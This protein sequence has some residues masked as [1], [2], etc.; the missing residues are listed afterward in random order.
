[1]KGSE[2][3]L[4]KANDLV[5]DLNDYPGLSRSFLYGLQ[6]LSFSLAQSAVIPVILGASL[7]LGTQGTAHLA[8]RIFFFTGLGSLLQVLFGHR[9]PIIEG[10]ASVFWATYISLAAMAVSMG[11]SLNLLRSD[12]QTGL[13][14]TGVIIGLIGLTG[15]IGKAVKLFTPAI[16]G[17]VMVLLTIQLSGT[18][19]KGML[20]IATGNQL[21]IIAPSI[22][23]IVIMTI[24]F[25]T[26]RGRGIWR[27]IGVF[28]GLLVGWF[29]YW[30]LGY[31][32]PISWSG[33]EVFALPKIFAWGY[34]TINWGVI[35]TCVCVGLILTTNIVVSIAAVSKMTGAIMNNKDYD[36]GTWINGLVIFITGAGAGVATVPYAASSGLIGL[37]GVASRIPFIIYSVFMMII[38]VIP[39]IGYLIAAIPPSVG[40][41]VFLVAF[42]QLL[43]VGLK[44]YGTLAMDHRDSFVIGISVILGTG[45]MSIPQEIWVEAPIIL[46]YVLGNG[47]VTGMLIC[48]LLEHVILPKRK[49]VT[50]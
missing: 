25:V 15:L 22:A 27:T 24:I 40:Y 6:W 26:L 5:Y 46:R 41:A 44:D 1:M 32:E 19:V 36:R 20:G 42:C 48:I 50:K 38:G 10:P 31:S 4:Q 21:S 18:F 28:I 13:M 17:T 39:A 16:T 37:S 3:Q 49:F 29:V 43:A 30:I 35:S 9:L 34:P 11:N 23:V 47:L 33:I 2:I 12:L 7:G 14:I 45:L 8:L